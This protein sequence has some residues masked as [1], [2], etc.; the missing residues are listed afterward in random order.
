MT[1]ERMSSLAIRVADEAVN[2]VIAER[3]M[4]LAMA[5]LREIATKQTPSASY[6]EI[7]VIC[8]FAIDDLHRRKSKRST[9]H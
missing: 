5:T 6:K 8:A 4:E 9:L 7:E 1:I 3:S 2:T